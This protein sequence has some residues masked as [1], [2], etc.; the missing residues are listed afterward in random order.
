M[1]N[2]TQTHGE[3]LKWVDRSAAAGRPWVVN[4]DEIGP[5]GDGVVPDSVDP[6]HD[7]VRHGGKK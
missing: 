1:G 3:T 4:L 2:M 6:N 7:S 5:A